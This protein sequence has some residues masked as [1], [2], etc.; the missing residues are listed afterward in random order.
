MSENEKQTPATP[1]PE[2]SPF[3]AE[4][5]SLAREFWTYLMENKKWWMV[6]ILV[7]VLLL[8]LLIALA[9]TG[10]GPFIYPLM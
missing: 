1:A 2:E 6:P 7:V 10:A 5:T 4:R 8:G 3:S 9:V